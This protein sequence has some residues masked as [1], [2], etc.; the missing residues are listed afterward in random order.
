MIHGQLPWATSSLQ[1][2]DEGP[3]KRTFL[4]VSC[5]A[6]SS[7]DFF[8]V[9]EQEEPIVD[10]LSEDEPFSSSSDAVR[11]PDTQRFEIIPV[12]RGYKWKNNKNLLPNILN[13]R[14]LALSHSKKRPINLP[15][16]NLDPSLR[17]FSRGARGLPS[18]SGGGYKEASLL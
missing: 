11:R 12:G 1:P 5:R 7:Q 4:N 16:A 18:S 13:A 17:I 8:D 14:F 9:G 3:H 15:K 6:G 2:L 10:V